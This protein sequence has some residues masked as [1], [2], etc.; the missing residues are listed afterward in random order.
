MEEEIW[1]DIPG[2]EGLYQASNLG[3]I[4][5]LER[6]AKKKYR[7]DRIVKERIMHGTKN[8]DGYLKVHFKN[9]AL[10]IDKGLF[11]HRL[12]AMTFIPNSDNLEQINHKDGNKLNNRVDNLEWCTNL[13]NQQHAWKNG[14]H[15][16][17]KGK[18][19]R[20][21]DKNNK[22]IKKW[23]TITEAGKKLGISASRIGEC[24]KNKNWTAGGY[25]WEFDK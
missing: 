4:K 19:I 21:L 11:I 22:I 8:Q 16:S 20:Q 14:L 5:S 12:I 17:T 15:K 24:C 10:N 23:N 9:K 25:R 6:I 7:N 1:K 2:Y 3:K 18:K 13:Y